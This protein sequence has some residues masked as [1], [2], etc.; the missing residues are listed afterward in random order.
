MLCF[1]LLYGFLFYDFFFYFI[2]L[3]AYSFQF[4]CES[5]YILKKKTQ[6]HRKS[7]AKILLHITFHKKLT[8]INA[9]CYFITLK[10]K[11][12]KK[13]HIQQLYNN[14]LITLHNA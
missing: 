12:N 13:M 6:T 7:K 11:I 5:I 8:Q 3:E 14:T 10:K 4:W 2:Q 1:F 9:I